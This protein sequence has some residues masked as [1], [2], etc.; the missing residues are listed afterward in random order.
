MSGYN[1]VR[2]L[3]NVVQHDTVNNLIEFLS[4]TTGVHTQNVQS[5]QKTKLKR[6]K[7]MVFSEISSCLDEFM[8]RERWG[9]TSGAVFA[10]IAQQ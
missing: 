2:F 7:G 1:T 5:Y 9:E 4:P 8:W 10:H 3:P 6:M